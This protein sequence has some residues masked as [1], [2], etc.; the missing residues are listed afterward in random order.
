MKLKSK[1]IYTYAK[2][3]KEPMISHDYHIEDNYLYFALCI[4]TMLLKSVLI[5]LNLDLQEGMAILEEEHIL[6]TA[7]LPEVDRMYLTSMKGMAY[8]LDF[9]GNKLWET[10]IG[11]KNASFKIA[12]DDE[13]LY[14]SN[15]SI[16]CLNKENGDILWINETFSQKVNCN[17]IYDEQHIYC[18]ELGGKVFCLDKFTGKTIWSYGNEEWIT[19]IEK[20]DESRLL[21]S[22]CHGWFY[23]LNAKT[24]ELLA[25]IMANGKLYTSPVIEGNRIYV[26]DQ[27]DVSKATSGNVT[28]YELTAQNELKEIYKLSVNGGGISTKTIIDE[29]RLFFASDDGYLYCIDKESGVE[30]MTRKKCKGTCRNIIVNENEIILLSDKGQV[31]C[32]ELI[33]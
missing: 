30:L 24:G 31:E 23:I 20:I 9:E 3:L 22:H 15:Y 29:Q 12:M 6:R 8:C 7:G 14:V 16:Y 33:L 27:D 25:K 32:F 28:C 1:W 10:T 26:G 21:V 4:G 17:I 19:N 13:R 5:K 11:K 18:G 2:G